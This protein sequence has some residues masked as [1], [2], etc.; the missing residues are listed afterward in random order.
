MQFAFAAINWHYLPCGGGRGGGRT[1]WRLVF[2]LGAPLLA[3][4]V[5]FCVHPRSPYSTLLCGLIANASLVFCTS[6]LIVTVLHFTF[7]LAFLFFT[8]SLQMNA[9]RQ[10]AACRFLLFHLILTVFFRN[11]C[12]TFTLARNIFY[13]IS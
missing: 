8:C 9:V 4:T 12:N 6:A 5:A 10:F 2:T 11:A 3:N 13:I 7:S 1:F